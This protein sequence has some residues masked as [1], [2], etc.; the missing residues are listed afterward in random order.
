[1]R[2][3]SDVAGVRPGPKGGDAGN[4]HH[5]Q[6][7]G[8]RHERHA[9]R[10]GGDHRAEHHLAADD[11]VVGLAVEFGG[12]IAREGERAA[13]HDHVAHPHDAA[14]RAVIEP[15]LQRIVL[16]RGVAALRRLAPGRERD[17]GALDG[18][19]QG[20]V[21]HDA[22]AVA[23]RHQPLGGLDRRRHD[24]AAVPGGEKNVQSARRHDALLQ[25]ADVPV[26]AAFSLLTVSRMSAVTDF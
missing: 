16:A 3:A 4:R 23:A 10:L 25:F 7:G 14:H 1:M 6:I 24:A 2:S 19:P 20:F 15:V 26:T 13:R 17:A 12:G 11:D 22:G 21:A 18:E 5:R 8:E 9:A